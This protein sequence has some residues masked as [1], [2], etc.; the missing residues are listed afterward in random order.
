MPLDSVCGIDYIVIGSK[1]SAMGNLLI[2]RKKISLPDSL[3]ISVDAAWSHHQH[4]C[5]FI[6]PPSLQLIPKFYLG[7]FSDFH[8]F[9]Q[10]GFERIASFS[11]HIICSKN[12]SGNP[13]VCLN[14]VNCNKL[15]PV[16]LR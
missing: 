5:C 16:F 9:S 12:L 10:M 6:R 4:F 1:F 13:E 2:V 14:L 8:L 15:S 7:Y 11:Q 3:E